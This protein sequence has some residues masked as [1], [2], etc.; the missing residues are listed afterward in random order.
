MPRRGQEPFEY[1]LSRST[2]KGVEVAEQ[3]EWGVRL[4][5]GRSGQH[6]LM[7]GRG[8][9]RWVKAMKAMY[10]KIAIARVARVEPRV[11]LKRE[12]AS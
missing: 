4:T 12:A 11:T 7:T 1:I 5:L 10:P 6:D 9:L 8:G 2:R 3:W